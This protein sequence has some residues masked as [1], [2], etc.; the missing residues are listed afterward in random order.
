MIGS[1]IAAK[2]RFDRIRYAQAWE[3]AD[4]L[5]AALGP[6]PGGTLLSIGAAGDNALALLTLDPARVVVV[7][8]ST[9]QLACLRLRIGAF[10]ALDHAELSELMG[11]RPSDRRGALLDRALDAVDD[12]EAAALWRGLRSEV[13]AHGA[14]GVGKFERYF[15]L[16]RTRLLPLVHSRTTIDAVFEPRPPEAR[17]AFLERR[18][19]TWRWRL[20]LNL[21]FSRAAMGAMGRD[22]AF[23]DHVEGSVAAHV[24]RRIRHAAV[25]M[26][27]SENP[28]LHWILKGGHGAALPMTWRSE[29]HATI[30][31]RLDRLDLRLGPLEGALA[32]GAR[33]DGFNLSDIFEYMSPAAY[34]R[35][36][37]DL[38]DAAT[39]GARLVYWNMM[40]PRR[41]PPGSADRVR[42]LPDLEAVLKLR[43]K[44]FFYA[45][46]VVEERA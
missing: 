9:A 35:T 43:D 37:A 7:D 1:E 33:Y 10:R 34:A 2:A 28:Y 24:S 25:A 12:P 30:R 27:P 26:D 44:A 22:R 41:C 16:F 42:P 15:R 18:F 3:D 11:A 6:R 19:E 45:D 46:L 8:L 31:D 13:L 29:H 38:L 14:G 5:C 36:H 17:A 20:L 40:V 32:D 23:F 4:V 21:F 39:R